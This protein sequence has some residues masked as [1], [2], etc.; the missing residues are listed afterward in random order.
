MLRE[1]QLPL[2]HIAQLLL[3]RVDFQGTVKSVSTLDT[4]DKDPPDQTPYWTADAG[5]SGAAL[6]GSHDGAHNERVNLESLEKKDGSNPFGNRLLSSD[7]LPNYA[8]TR[9]TPYI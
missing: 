6:P 4:T 2:L 5:S 9:L 3:A 8:F 1:E 7:P